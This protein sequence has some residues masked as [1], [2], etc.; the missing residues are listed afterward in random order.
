M[1]PH[2]P[3]LALSPRRQ[4]GDVEA[5]GLVRLDVVVEL[6][7]IGCDRAGV[8]R[9][10]VGGSVSATKRTAPA[11]TSRRPQVPVATRWARRRA[12][13]M[14]EASHVAVV[15]V[16]CRPSGSSARSQSGQSSGAPT[17]RA[18]SS[19]SSIHGASE[20]GGWCR[21]CWACRQ[22]SSATHSP[23]S[24]RRNPVMVRCM[25]P[26]DGA[27]G[28][29]TDGRPFHLPD[30]AERWQ[31]AGVAL[32]QSH[33]ICLRS[34]VRPI[35]SHG[36][37]SGPRVVAVDWHP[38]DAAAPVE[39]SRRRRDRCLG[40]RRAPRRCDR[41]PTGRRPT[42]RGAGDGTRDRRP[43]GACPGSERRAELGAQG[44]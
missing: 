44:R 39:S 10:S 20:K 33:C 37:D 14:V 41:R 42:S 17:R 35:I 28:R 40:G 11:S 27:T 30:T 12:A 24:S 29:R 26:H 13:G 38:E 6:G 19:S 25:S 31:P 7:G 23:S 1:G 4:E 5:G 16:G 32:R 15:L 3:R 9:T 34:V 22:E 43:W 18:L 8:T 2:R 36:P 21:M